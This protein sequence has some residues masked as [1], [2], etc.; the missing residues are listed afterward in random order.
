[1]KNSIPPRCRLLVA[2]TAVSALACA[3]GV[4][5]ADA[6][7]KSVSSPADGA[8]VDGRIV[9]L[10]TVL[11]ALQPQLD[12][13][14]R[15]YL[16]AR[17]AMDFKYAETRERV[18]GE[19]VER[20]VDDQVLA[21]EARAQGSTAEALL[22]AVTPVAVTDAD[23]ESA[24]EA[25][26]GQLKAPYTAVA[27]QL[28]AHLAEENAA[29][30][31]RAYLDRL[32]AKYHATVLREPQRMEVPAVGPLRG[33][34]DAP[35]TIVEFADFECPYC[36]R[37]ETSLQRLMAAHPADVRL[38]FRHL[39]LTR[40]HPLA[41]GAAR[42]AVC[43]ERQG[44]FWELHD[45]MFAHQRELEF[46]SVRK[47]VPGL[48][49]DEPR[50]WKCLEQERPEETVSRDTT[51]AAEI[52]LTTTPVLFVNGRFVDGAVPYAA[53][54]SLVEAEVQRAHGRGATTASR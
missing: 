16:A 13:A 28:K 23:T 19:H 47:A 42:S 51:A 8:I 21:L 40:L 11:E 41:E 18:V 6:L 7:P 12:S 14:E 17:R 54:L 44:R 39:P 43:A 29:S 48:G 4:A 22:A 36:A 45:W 30:A 50:F 52:G 5:A 20:F 3:T 53:L 38:A 35:V 26:K 9:P 34:A 37:L 25:L 49:I 31:R 32:R 10:A 2:V 15:Q 1:M 24:Y 27:G 33:P 46:E